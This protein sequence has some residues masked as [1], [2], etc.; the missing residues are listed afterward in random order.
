MRVIALGGAGD[1]GRLVVSDLAQSEGVEEVVIADLNVIRADRIKDD[2]PNPKAKVS[3]RGIDARDH[4]GLVAAI[5]GFDVAVSTIGP[6]YAFE[7]KVARAA[8]D[9]GIKYVSICD[10]FDAFLDVFELDGYVKEKKGLVLTGMGWTPGLSNVLARLGADRLSKVNKIHVAW[11]GAVNDS[12]GT[13]VVKH[14]MHIFAGKIP[15]FLNGQQTMIPAGSGAEVLKFPHP[16][17]NCPVAHVGHPEPVTIPRF[18]PGLKEVTLKGGLTP[19]FWQ[20]ITV[21]A[22]KLHLFDTPR[23]IDL[24]TR[25]LMPILGPTGKSGAGCAGLRVDIYGEMDGKEQHLVFGAAEK[26]ARLTGIPAS[27]GAQMVGRGEIKKNVTGVVAPEAIIE[28]RKFLNELGK[29][30]IRIYEGEEMEKVIN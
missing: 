13:A 29:R 14:T 23:Q 3:V 2:I 28:P 30:G 17:G 27:I 7:K 6:F 12:E 9:A 10:D 21:G 22:A 26:M 5:S 8:V 15:S 1:M 18:I 25:I 19:H 16:I 11:S 20:K 4:E 24:F